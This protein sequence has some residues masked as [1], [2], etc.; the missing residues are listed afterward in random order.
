MPG[1]PSLAQAADG[2]LRP[3]S[4]QNIYVYH[5]WQLSMRE[6]ILRSDA[7][8]NTLPVLPLRV[9]PQGNFIIARCKS[10]LCT[11]SF[12]MG[13]WGVSG[14]AFHRSDRESRLYEMLLQEVRLCRSAP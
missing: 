8:S 9:V 3:F 14:R 4:K 11:R 6:C 7:P 5:K 12:P 2:K 13:D 1:A 10:I